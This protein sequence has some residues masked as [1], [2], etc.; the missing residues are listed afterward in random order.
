MGCSAGCATWG[1]R[2]CLWSGWLLEGSRQTIW[3]H[4]S[5]RQ[6]EVNTALYIQNDTTKVWP[7]GNRPRSEP[8][9]FGC[10]ELYPDTETG[11]ADQRVPF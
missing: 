10:V 5:R 9:L 3:D 4:H 6:S 8:S 7:S 11:P 1:R 2:C